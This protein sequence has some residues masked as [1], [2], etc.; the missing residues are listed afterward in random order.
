MSFP[1][2]TEDTL[3]TRAQT[4][5]ALTKAG[6]PVSAATL[7]TKATRGG[8]PLFQHFG[9]FVLYRWGNSLQWARSRLGPP[10]SST[11]ELDAAC[12]D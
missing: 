12:H 9:P 3:L 2:L 4:A 10:T 5:D 8:G 7:A 6:F 11:S 1:I